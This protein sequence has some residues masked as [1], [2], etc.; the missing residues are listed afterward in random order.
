MRKIIQYTQVIPIILIAVYIGFF[1]FKD[2]QIYANL[3]YNYLELT[4]NILVSISLI[5]FIVGGYKSWNKV[6]IRSFL[7]VALL[8]IITEFNIEN[9]YQTYSFIVQ[10]FIITLI[11]TQIPVRQLWR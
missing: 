2:F 4:D 10:L 6:A 9:Y 5:A 1:F 3:H 8:N 11:L 7:S